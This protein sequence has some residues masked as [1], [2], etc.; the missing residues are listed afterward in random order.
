MTRILLG[1]CNRRAIASGA[2]AS[3][4]ETIAP[5]T[6]PTGQDRP[7]SKCVAA[8]A[9]TVVNTT[10]PIAS[11]EIGR[12]L[13]RNSRQLI[14][15]ADEYISGGN[16]SSSTSSGA[17][18]TGGRPGTSANKTPVSTR[19]IAGGTFHRF[20]TTPTAASATSRSTKVWISRVIKFAAGG[21]VELLNRCER[22]STLGMTAV[23]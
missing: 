19:R 7:S 2:T 21:M 8:P 18:C 10:Q 5:R 4:G 13:K 20:A 16:T 17:S 9:A 15:T 3:G 11:R 12:R 23:A 22:F 14:A 1:S 6:N